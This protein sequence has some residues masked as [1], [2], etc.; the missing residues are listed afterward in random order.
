MSTLREYS[1]H[2][3]IRPIW[4]GGAAAHESVM[5][6][7]D[8]YKAKLAFPAD[9]ILCV[10]S[11]DLRTEYAEGVDYALEDGELVRLPHSRMPFIPLDRF[12]PPEHR[13]GQDFGCTEPGRPFLGFGEG[14][15]MIRYMIDV[16]YRHDAPWDGPV[17]RPKK[18]AC[19][20]F[21]GKLSRGE[22]AVLLFYGDSI[23]TGANSSG[24]VGVPPFAPSF[25]EMTAS[26][27]AERFGYALCADVKPY[28]EPKPIARTGEK[29]LHYVNT[30]RGG[31]DSRWGLAHAE[32]RAA[33]YRPDLMILAFGMNDGLTCAEYVDLTK[34]IVDA[35]RGP[36]PDTDVLL[37][38]PMLPHWRAEGFVRHQGEYEE[39][40]AA[41]AAADARLALAPMTSMH[42]HLLKRKEYYHMT[43]NNVNH[44]NDFLA[45]IHA[46][47]ILASMGL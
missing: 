13:D 35:V 43:G 15:S 36:S 33:A 44:P 19:A 42:R 20:G 26:A 21:L 17:P 38:S 31:R 41:L 47:T 1:L 23:T 16:T 27:L 30:A 24:I 18:G 2:E 4:E 14:D 40:L 8:E 39:G 9:A 7:E 25:P 29:I 45:R 10:L 11:A 3:Y 37:L 12:Y 28:E 32:E 6:R 34:R 5:F 22:E 46:M